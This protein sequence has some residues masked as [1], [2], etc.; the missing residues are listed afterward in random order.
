MSWGRYGV[1]RAG[2]DS[3]KREERLR[4]EKFERKHIG[5]AWKFDGCARLSASRSR[6]DVKG[7]KLSSVNQPRLAVN[8]CHKIERDNAIRRSEESSLSQEGV[9]RNDENVKKVADY[10][11]NC[12]ADHFY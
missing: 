3:K 7:F 12:E 10:R 11:I 1:A 9:R 5:M 4:Y 6:I 2:S 8:L